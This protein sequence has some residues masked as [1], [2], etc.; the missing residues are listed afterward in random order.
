MIIGDTLYHRG[1]VIVLWR[2]ITHEEAEKVLNDCHSGTCGGYQSGYATAKNILRVGYFW[3][4]M[5]NDYIIVVRNC[6]AC[7]IFDRKSRI[8]PTP[9]Q[10]ILT[11]GPFTKWGID[12]M[13]C[14]PTSAEGHGYIVV[15][16]DY[17]TKWTEAIPTLI[18]SGKTAALFF[19]NHVVSRFGVPQAIV[20][21]HG[22]HFHNHMVVELATKL[23]LSHDSSTLY[24]PQANGTLEEEAHFLELIQL[25]ETRRDATLANESHKKQVKAQFDKNVKPRVFSEG[26]LVL[27]YDQE[28][29]KLGAGKF[30][31]LWMGPYIV[32]HVLAKGAYELVDYDGI[33]LS[34]PQNGL[35]L[36]HYYA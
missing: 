12:F 7:Q 24:Y 15:A 18:N 26:D 16:V 6:H 1:I 8:P 3:P 2:C 29:D 22:L 13:T 32:K 9:L 33:P 14:N 11:I 21:N 30:Q 31:S 19:F 20:K 4:T 25:D 28:F 35:Y 36:K 5:F 34:Q 23:G 17:F 10:P 27:L